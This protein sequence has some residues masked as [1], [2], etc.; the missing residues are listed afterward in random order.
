MHRRTIDKRG[1]IRLSQRSESDAARGCQHR[2]DVPHPSERNLSVD[3][4]GSVGPNDEWRIL[5]RRE[6]G[7]TIMAA[8][9]KAA[10]KPAAKKKAAKKK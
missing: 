4:L 8:K 10:K 5:V 7:K 9:K 1:G 6:G 3:S 2:D